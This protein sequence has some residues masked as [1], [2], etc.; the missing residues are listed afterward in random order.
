MKSKHL[1]GINKVIKTLIFS[2]PSLLN[3]LLLL[4]ILYFISSVLAVFLFKE[5]KYNANYVNPLFNFTNF[6]SSLISLFRAS[7]GEDW[8]MFM[9]T[10]GENSGMAI[11]SRIFF[12]IYTF[13]S[14]IVMLKM[15]QLVVM[16]QFDEFYFNEDNPLN[17][18]DEISE[19]FRKTWNQ[20]TIKHRGQRINSHRII[21]FFYHLE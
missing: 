13:A 12:L 10:L 4:L 14:S 19:V 6:H 15:F 16:Q 17:S 5:A 11:T 9:Y 3:V 18:F 2:F 7:T 8:H 1:Q 21:D 20:Y